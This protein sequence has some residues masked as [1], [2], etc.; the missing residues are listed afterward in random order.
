MG[1]KPSEIKQYKPAIADLPRVQS[2]IAN[3]K[4]VDPRPTIPLELNLDSFRLYA[5]SALSG[6][7]SRIGVYPDRTQLEL[8]FDIAKQMLVEEQ[9]ALEKEARK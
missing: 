7:I 8:C 2:Q 4:P 1:R 5:A 9:V 3:G 6:I